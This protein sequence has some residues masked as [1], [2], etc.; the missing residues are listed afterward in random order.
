MQKGMNNMKEGFGNLLVQDFYLEL[1]EY[2]GKVLFIV[3]IT[4]LCLKCGGIYHLIFYYYIN[5]V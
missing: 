5:W 1:Q 4:I 2:K 3:K